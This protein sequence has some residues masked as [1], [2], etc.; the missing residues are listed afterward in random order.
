M[1]TSEVCNF[2]GVQEINLTVKLL[3][4]IF[5]FLAVKDFVV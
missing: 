5:D 4:S 1:L 3:F 2:Y